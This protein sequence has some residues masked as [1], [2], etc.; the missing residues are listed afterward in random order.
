MIVGW[1]KEE[2]GM[3]YVVKREGEEL[4]GFCLYFSGKW[5]RVGRMKGV[6]FDEKDG[7]MM[8]SNGGKDRMG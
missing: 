1:F 4:K 7:F 8:E 2:K 5:D 6:D 3:E